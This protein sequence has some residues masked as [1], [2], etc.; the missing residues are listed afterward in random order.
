MK[1]I[2]KMTDATSYETRAARSV[3]EMADSPY[4]DLE[5][6]H[7]TPL[8]PDRAEPATAV[9]QMSKSLGI[10]LDGYQQQLFQA[11]EIHAIWRSAEGPLIVGEFCLPNLHYSFFG[12]EFPPE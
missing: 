12:D 11:D 10:P 8:S 3:Q 2:S 6:H 9:R 5:A 1:R 7:I 4:V